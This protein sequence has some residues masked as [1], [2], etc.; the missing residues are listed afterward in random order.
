M[1][2]KTKDPFLFVINCYELSGLRVSSTK[3]R[4]IISVYILLPLLL[5]LYALIIFN[6][7]YKNDNI[8]EFAEV[9]EAVSTFGQVINNFNHYTGWQI[10][11]D[12]NL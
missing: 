8:F 7:N 12:H 1:S 5:I 9:F 10:S 3:M 11:I 6:F 2:S 4:R